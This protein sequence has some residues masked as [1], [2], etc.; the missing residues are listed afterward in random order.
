MEEIAPKYDV[1]VLGT[2]MFAAPHSASR[3]RCLDAIVLLCLRLFYDDDEDDDD[4]DDHANSAEHRLDRV[5]PVRVCLSKSTIDCSSV[6]PLTTLPIIKCSQCQ[7]E[8]GVA[9]RSQ[10]SLRRVR[11][12]TKATFKQGSFRAC[13]YICVYDPPSFATDVYIRANAF[14]NLREAASVNIETVRTIQTTFVFPCSILGWEKKPVA[15][16]ACPR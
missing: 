2:G 9:Y 7:G 13:V 6:P 12:S 10:R 15:N 1:V 14:S 3:Q 8:K 16:H 4:E 5:Y 11:V